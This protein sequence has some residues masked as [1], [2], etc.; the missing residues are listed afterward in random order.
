[1][2]GRF[3]NESE[4]TGWKELV[5]GAHT[6]TQFKTDPETNDTQ[7][8][9]QL[10]SMAVGILRRDNVNESRATAIAVDICDPHTDTPDSLAARVKERYPELF[11]EVGTNNTPRDRTLSSLTEPKY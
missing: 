11:I 8:R 2:Y 7:R 1:M 10:A 5:K 9:N 3:G 4:A 6:P